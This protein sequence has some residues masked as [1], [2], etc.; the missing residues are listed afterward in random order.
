MNSEI[1]YTTMEYIKRKAYKMALP[2]EFVVS[3]LIIAASR[4]VDR[5][6]QSRDGY[7]AKAPD[8]PALRTYLGSGT[9]VLILDPFVGTIASVAYQDLTIIPTYYVSKG[10]YLLLQEG[11]S[12]TAW[13]AIDVTARW[14]F[15]AI[16]PDIA[17]ATAELVIAA[18][19][20]R[21]PAWLRIVAEIN[22]N[23]GSI[24]GPGIPPRVREVCKQWRM[25]VPP[26]I[27]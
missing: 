22:P 6:T 20:E 16:P 25:K 10:R 7:F 24:A 11:L 27:S 9:H 5:L 2:D 12:W 26:T 4:I 19:R 14:G 8:A 1:E 18:W 21:D 13:A 3:D 17:D 15:E 23:V